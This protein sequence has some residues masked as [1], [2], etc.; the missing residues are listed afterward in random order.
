MNL[1]GNLSLNKRMAVKFSHVRK[2]SGYEKY[3]STSEHPVKHRLFC[4]GTVLTRIR[5][6]AS[7]NKKNLKLDVFPK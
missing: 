4:S 6:F 5:V 1:K 3:S 2:D 7:L